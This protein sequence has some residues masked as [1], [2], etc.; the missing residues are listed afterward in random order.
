MSLYDESRFPLVRG[1]HSHFTL[2]EA[3]AAWNLVLGDR[4]IPPLIDGF[5][6]HELMPGPQ[7]G[8]MARD[9]VRWAEYLVS[10]GIQPPAPRRP[11]PRR[12]YTRI[13]RIGVR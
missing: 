11:G 9:P 3:K 8:W 4:R 12:K 2:E 10:Q 7:G 5:E 1:S 13:R 6:D